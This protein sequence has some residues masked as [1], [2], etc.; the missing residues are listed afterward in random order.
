MLVT[1]LVILV[2]CE[3]AEKYED[4]IIINPG[5]ATGA[6]SIITEA[7]LPS[8]VLMDIDGDKVIKSTLAIVLPDTYMMECVCRYDASI[9]WPLS[10]LNCV[11]SALSIDC[12]AWQHRSS[13]YSW[14]DNRSTPGCSCYPMQFTDNTNN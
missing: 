3:Q 4:R 10:P 2:F 14:G 6:F 8:F 11:L 9:A 13:Y 1:P 7:P 5:S 12:Q